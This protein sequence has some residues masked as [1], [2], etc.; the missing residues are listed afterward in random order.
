MSK[1]DEKIVFD[2]RETARTLDTNGW[3][4]IKGNPLSKVGVFDYSGARLGEGFEPNKIYKVYRSAEALSDEQTIGSFKLLPWIDDHPTRLLGTAESGRT[5]AEKKGI[6]GVIGEDVYFDGEYLRGN[7][8]V[9]SDEMAKKIES[10]KIELSPG[11]LAKY[12]L[13]KGNYN[14]QEYDAIQTH[15]RGNHLALVDQG[16]SGPDVRVLDSKEDETQE[17]SVKEDEKQVSA[18]ASK[19]E[20]AGGLTLEGLRDQLSALSQIVNNFITQATASADKGTKDEDEDKKDDKKDDEKPAMDAAE[21]RKSI[22]LE[23]SERNKLAERLS[24]H[25]GT[26]DSAA[27]SLDEVAQYGIKKLGLTCK[28]GQENAVLEGY[29]AG[30][31]V[32]KPLPSMDSSKNGEVNQVDAFLKGGK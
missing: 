26:F 17:T 20:G 2:A 11:Y 19:D 8:K 5:P 9:F 27:M 18:E 23:T 29:L 7:I 21:L 6:S 28:P 12:V 15:L 16:R 30:A 32:S 1:H 10:G 31:R 3:I 4:E 25:V 24:W 22:Y 14:G 13:S